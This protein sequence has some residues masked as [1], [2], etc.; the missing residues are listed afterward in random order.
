M[1]IE[2]QFK[3]LRI[4]V[5]IP[6]RKAQA[7]IG[8]C[9]RSLEMQI[10]KPDEVII[11]INPPGDP[12]FMHVKELSYK[13]SLPIRILLGSESVGNARNMGVAAASGDI[14]AFIDSDEVAHPYWLQYIEKV[15]IENPGAMVVSG[16]VIYV[17]S[18]D[19]VLI[20][21]PEINRVFSCSPGQVYNMRMGNMAFKRSVINFAGNFDPWFKVCLED[22]DFIFRLIEYKIKMLY[23]EDIIVYHIIKKISTLQEISR[24]F[25]IGQHNA[26][27]FAKHPNIITLK[28]FYINLGHV[29]L[30]TLGAIVAVVVKTLT[31]PVLIIMPSII[32]KIVKT[33][34]K[35]N[36]R[37][38][39]RQLTLGYVIDLLSTLGFLAEI[40]NILIKR[41]R[42]A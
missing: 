10:R 42:N 37:L 34:M 8:R 40:I 26:R 14:I 4:S 17:E 35:K 33:I 24:A 12:T 18:L 28:I 7:T 19:Q 13:L 2:G 38:M 9:L 23:C 41:L 15:F 20:N 6:A 25:Y 30:I 1:A 5:V 39:M 27:L 36:L 11:I 21:P 31:I 32:Y 22:T 29:F 3:R 16:P